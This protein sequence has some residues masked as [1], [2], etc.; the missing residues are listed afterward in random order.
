VSDGARGSE[1]HPVDVQTRFERFPLAIKG[2]FVLRGADGNPH[3][4]RFEWASVRRVP[5]GPAAEISMEDRQVDVAPARDLFVPFEVPVAELE[6]GWYAVS[7]GIRVDGGRTWETR[8]RPFSMPWPRNDV[9]RAS[10]AVGKDVA[11]GAARV[12]VERVELTPDAAVVWW[13]VPEDDPNAARTAASIEARL[14]ADGAPL[15][16]LPPDT[17]IK[18]AEPRGPS[19]GRTITYPVFRRVS[20]LALVLTGPAGV[21]SESLPLSLR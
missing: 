6:P 7:S 8:G 16:V 21:K 15:E 4:V 19:E 10:V 13:R 18:V 20:S 9:R 12:R 11:V 14:L 1:G 5:K 3:L 2:A 17:R